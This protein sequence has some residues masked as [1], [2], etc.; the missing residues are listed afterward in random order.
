MIY[1]KFIIKEN[2]D[3][4]YTIYFKKDH[5]FFTNYMN[6]TIKQVKKDLDFWNNYK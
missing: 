3:L 4:T 6:A 5:S 1:K 2:K